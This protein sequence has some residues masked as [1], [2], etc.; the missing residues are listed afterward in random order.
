M[1]IIAGDSWGCGE[2]NL[3]NGPVLVHKGLEQYLIDDGYSVVNFS[4]A[5]N[6]NHKI[7]DS[8]NVITESNL[9]KYLSEPIDLILVFQTEWSRDLKHTECNT[10]S[11][12]K[13]G[14]NALACWQNRLSEISCNLQC[15]IGLIGGH[16][17]TIWLDKFEKEY[18]GL[19][20]AC[21]SV[22]NLILNDNHR[23]SH[24]TLNVK[25][26][27]IDNIE[28]HYVKYSTKEQFLIDCEQALERIDTWIENKHWFPDCW[29][30][31]RFGY[32]KLYDF[33]KAQKVI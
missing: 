2:W 14:T 32:K 20:I 19:F 5:G 6:S 23:V 12:N 33:L 22:T 7:L 18:P 25:L 28:K 29:H 27:E 24:P 30:P 4:I 11:T 16:S 1:I 13:V 31:S 15:K 3:D 10:C 26:D 17:D 21:Q 8:L 9:I